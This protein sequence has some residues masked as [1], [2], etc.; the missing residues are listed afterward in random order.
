MAVGEAAEAAERRALLVEE[1]ASNSVEAGRYRG[2]IAANE[3][4]RRDVE[5]RIEQAVGASSN[6]DSGFI[7]IL[8]TFRI[9][10]RAPAGLRRG[11]ATHCKHLLCAC[12]QV[13]LHARLQPA[14][15]THTHTHARTCVHACITCITCIT[16][17]AHAAMP[18]ARSQAVRLLEL[19]FQVAVRD[20]VISDQRQAISNLWAILGASGLT[21]EQVLEVAQAQGIVMEVRRHGRRLL[22]HSSSCCLTESACLGCCCC[23]G[24]DGDDASLLN[25]RVPHAAAW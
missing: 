15:C 19:K 11:R 3:A 18:C 20:Q 24:G 2:E 13:A 14:M 7:K 10:V 1:M 21:R 8:S 5:A 6:A 4:A 25:A 22:T 17:A 12:A 9:Q 23:T 16:P